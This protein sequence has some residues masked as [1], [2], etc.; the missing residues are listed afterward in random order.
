VRLCIQQLIIDRVDRVLGVVSIVYYLC[1]QTLFWISYFSA[2]LEE[3]G[4]VTP[5]MTA[6]L[7]QAPPQVQPDATEDGYCRLCER[8]KPVRA[9]HCRTCQ[10]CVL[11]WDHHCGV[12]DNDVGFRNQK[13]FILLLFWV[14]VF[15]LGCT[16]LIVIKWCLHQAPKGWGSLTEIFLYVCVFFGGCYGSVLLVFCLVH[17]FYVCTNSTS[18]EQTLYPKNRY[19]PYYHGLYRNWT[20]VFGSNPLT[21]F[22][23]IFT[24]PGDGMN[25]TTRNVPPV[26][27]KYRRAV[28]LPGAV[29][30]QQQ[31][32]TQPQEI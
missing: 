13:Y 22:L 28:T 27:A 19:N 3:A 32:Q 4:G 9:H 17:M 8:P 12:I 25:W 2:M 24:T 26:P 23:P 30:P 31:R 10:R 5:A 18:L 1:T 16:V 14:S 7:P 11:K 6:Q 15:A 29:Q 20:S 21:W